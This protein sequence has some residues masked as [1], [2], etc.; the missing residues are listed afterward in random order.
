ML[1]AILGGRVV[2]FILTFLFIS[3]FQHLYDKNY[4]ITWKKILK[5][6][7]ILFSCLH[8]LHLLILTSKIFFTSN[9]IISL[10]RHVVTKVETTYLSLSCN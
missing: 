3:I 5:I 7:R 1:M 6:V 2:I 4:Y 10:A 8:L 9:T